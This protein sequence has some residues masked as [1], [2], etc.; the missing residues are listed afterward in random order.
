MRLFGYLSSCVSIVAFLLYCLD[1]INAGSGS[2]SN[3][4]YLFIFVVAS[5]V[6][7][8]VNSKFLNKKIINYSNS[9]IFCF[10]LYA[11]ANYVFDGSSFEEVW[12][13]TLG[14]TGG[15]VFGL[16][17]G[18]L[19]SIQLAMI[20][21]PYE[22]NSRCGKSNLLLINSLIAF[23]NIRL[24]IVAA[25]YFEGSR[26]DIFLVDEV[27]ISYQRI[28]AYLLIQFLVLSTM[29]VLYCLTAK[30][31]TVRKLFLWIGL[32]VNAGLAIFIS[33]I[34][35]SNSGA[36]SIAATFML[37]TA[38]LLDLNKFYSRADKRISLNLNIFKVGVRVLFI[39]CIF[40][41]FSY[42][43]IIVFQVNI[44]RFRLFGYD[45]GDLSSFSSRWQ[46]IGDNALFHF[47]YSPIFGHTR[48]D[49]L[50]T[51]VGTYIHSLF[52]SVATHLGWVGFLVFFALNCTIVLDLVKNF[53]RNSACTYS[54][55]AF[56]F[57]R[58]IL[59]LLVILMGI[60]SSFFTWLPYW[61]SLG[62]F[63]LN[64]FVSRAK[65]Q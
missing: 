65:T 38:F 43:W 31:M 4:T 47:S 13:V 27:D 39:S 26:V 24:G 59:L 32:A 45:S 56:I 30:K 60:V 28:G 6:T 10:L 16:I 20:C 49:A 2:T 46:I 12:A 54:G 7:S 42:F 61:F 57:F 17:A 53:Y 37:V 19:L 11:V 58:I 55:K 44:E 40:L 52:L 8:V 51:G 1:G 21:S 5:I 36:V 34:L 14:S 35:G 63:G 48:V 25:N 62:F 50:T 41:I 23:I 22:A 3:L 64:T 9:L 18:F 33:Q 15:M 29:A